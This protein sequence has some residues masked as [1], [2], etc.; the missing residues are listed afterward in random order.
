MFMTQSPLPLSCILM[1]FNYLS[2]HPVLP[3]YSSNVGTHHL[4]SHWVS[5]AAS[6]SMI[7]SVVTHLQD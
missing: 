6:H 5:H 7:S 4:P 2:S 1:T 3:D